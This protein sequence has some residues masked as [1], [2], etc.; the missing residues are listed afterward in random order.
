VLRS[1]NG[2]LALKTYIC[3]GLD[4]TGEADIAVTFYLYSGGIQFEPLLYPDCATN[5]SFQGLSN[6]SFM[7]YLYHPQSSTLA[8]DSVLK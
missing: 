4:V 7:Y 8:A 2:F 1:N 5:D 3:K 6:I